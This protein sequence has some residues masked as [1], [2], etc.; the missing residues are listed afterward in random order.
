M[1]RPRAKTFAD[2]LPPIVPREEDDIS[3]LSDEMAAVLYPG[4]RRRPFRMG[5]VFDAFEGPEYPR[6]VQLA[7]MSP[8][9]R[10]SKDGERQ[11][12]HASFGAGEAAA[13]RDLYDLVGRR[14]GTDVLVDEKKVPYARELW[15]PLFLI[16]LGAGG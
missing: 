14:P 9:Y 5:L 1:S 10:E 3:H 12:H 13:F 6:A 8:V 11:R 15:I 7:R 2:R 16:H 4:R